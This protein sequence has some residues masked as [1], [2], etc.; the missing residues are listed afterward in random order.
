[1]KQK[2]KLRT[3]TPCSLFS[4]IIKIAELPSKHLEKKPQQQ[5]Q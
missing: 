1:M 3:N 4:T 5:Q 2:T